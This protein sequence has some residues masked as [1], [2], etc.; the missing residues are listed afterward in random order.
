MDT[1][2]RENAIIID[3]KSTV[4]CLNADCA[5]NINSA[6][7]LKWVG[8]DTTGKCAGIVKVKTKKKENKK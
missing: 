5:N 7:N 6:C 2:K 1:T 4:I 3:N 8:V